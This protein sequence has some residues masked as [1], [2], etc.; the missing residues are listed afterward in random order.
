[1]NPKVSSTDHENHRR[2]EPALDAKIQFTPHNSSTMYQGE[3][4]HFCKEECRLTYTQDSLNTWLASRLL[5][6]K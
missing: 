3:I 2:D 4:I 6:D 5:S 1:M